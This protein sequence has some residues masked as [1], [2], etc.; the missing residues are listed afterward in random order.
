[1]LR[2][3]SLAALAALAVCLTAC[4]SH[5]TADPATALAKDWRVTRLEANEVEAEAGL[6]LRFEDHKLSGHSGVNAFHGP[7]ELAS[8]GTFESGP[9]AMTRRAGPPPAMERESLFMVVLERADHWEVEGGVM[10]LLNGESVMLVAERV[11]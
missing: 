11:D 3:L 1:M 7:A 10:R 9:F 2:S 4:A 5:G 8:D 6:R